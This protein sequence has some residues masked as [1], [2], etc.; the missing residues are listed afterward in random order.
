MEFIADKRDGCT[1]TAIAQGLNIPKSSLTALLQ[2]L[3]S[4]GY[5]QR[6]PESGIFTIGVQVLWLSNSYLRNLNL[7]KLGQPMVAE[8]FAQVKEFTILAIPNGT[9]YVTICTES[10]P[11]IFGHTL[12]LG[13]RGPLFCSALGRAMLAY[14]PVK[15]VD[16]ILKTGPRVKV[17]Q[18]TKTSLTDIRASLEETRSNG[19]AVSFEEAL[20]GV[21]GFATPVFGATGL[22]V[23]AFG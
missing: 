19:Y 2:D 10:V 13:S 17:T 8:I 4:K 23:A 12:Q 18:S 14:M 22:P 3:L 20:S 7:V 6:A 11:S 5:L 15:Q 21:V 9:E 16:D 1:H